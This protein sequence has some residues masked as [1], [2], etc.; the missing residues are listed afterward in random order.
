MN[1]PSSG[2][3]HF[4]RGLFPLPHTLGPNP[5]RQVKLLHPQVWPL[6]DTEAV[7]NL[8]RVQHYFRVRL[9]EEVGAWL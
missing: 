7:F 4:E 1:H 9:V 5:T 2:L 6:Q 3:V 8:T